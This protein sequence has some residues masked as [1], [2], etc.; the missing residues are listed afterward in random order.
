LQLEL[1]VP[2]DPLCRPACGVR[3][4]SRKLTAPQDARRFRKDDN[5]LA[6]HLL[7]NLEGSGLSGPRATGQDDKLGIVLRSGTG[8]ALCHVPTLSNISASRGSI[9]SRHLDDFAKTW[10]A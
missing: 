1:H 5:V 9:E 10:R 8:A 6:D 7:K 2:D 3:G 4:C